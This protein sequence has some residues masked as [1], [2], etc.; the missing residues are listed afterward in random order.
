MTVRETPNCFPSSRSGGS[1]SPGL[2]LLETIISMIASV[3]LSDSRG[4]RWIA[5]KAVLSLSSTVLIEL[6]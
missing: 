1:M 6:T 4:S 5:V 3:T 2:S